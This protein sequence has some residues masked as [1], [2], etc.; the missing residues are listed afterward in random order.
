[1]K[2]S[3]N[4]QMVRYGQNNKVELETSVC[5]TIICR[6]PK[7]L[8]LR[9]HV[10]GNNDCPPVNQHPTKA[11]SH[12]PIRNKVDDNESKMQPLNELARKSENINDFRFQQNCIHV[13]NCFTSLNKIVFLRT[14]IQ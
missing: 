10:T 8:K 7:K 14:Q 4:N 3:R 9:S 11:H 2:S 6:P 5:S 1:M 13:S 12:I